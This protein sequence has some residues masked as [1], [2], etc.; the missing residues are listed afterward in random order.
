MTDEYLD[1]FEWTVRKLIPI[2]KQYYWDNE[3]IV[4]ARLLPTKLKLWHQ[5]VAALGTLVRWTDRI[6][7]SIVDALGLTL[8]RFDHV[9][10]TMTERD[11]DYSR[12]VVTE[13][14]VSG[15]TT[16]ASTSS[17]TN[18]SRSSSMDPVGTSTS[19]G[20]LE[21]TTAG[22]ISSTCCKEDNCD[23]RA[24][25]SGDETPTG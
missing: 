6:G 12:R 5:S 14:L 20:V 17:I 24:V 22:V 3:T 2:P 19:G 25:P 15:A 18:T 8:S 23:T 7:K 11:W 10:S 16:G 4:D 1:P 21:D 13:R 9:T